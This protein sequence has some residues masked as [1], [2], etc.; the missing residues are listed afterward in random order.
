MASWVQIANLALRRLGADRIA[1]LTEDS[2]G[3]RAVNDV[4]ET[5]R[6]QVLRL[7]P[8]NCATTLKAVS[9]DAT[10]PAFG[11]DNAYTLPT[12]PYCLRV[13]RLYSGDY[14]DLTIEYKVNGR[15]IHTDSDAPL[16]LLYIA[17]LTDPEQ[18]DATLTVAIAA[19]IAAEIAFRLTNSRT[20]EE[21]MEKWA[22]ATLADARHVDATEGTPDQIEA[23]YII[24]ERDGAA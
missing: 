21:K 8:W 4:Y 18:F 16:N 22:A 23:D 24:G 10:A 15:K 11:Y 14:P 9:A 2:E 12:D 7:H 17:R 6:D 13:L 3:A 5:V 19:H 20:A 1:S